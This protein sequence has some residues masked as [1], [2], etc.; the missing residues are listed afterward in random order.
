MVKIRTNIVIMGTIKVNK[1]VSKSGY[2][3]FQ[4]LIAANEDYKT[5]EKLYLSSLINFKDREWREKL[6]D[7]DVIDIIASISLSKSTYADKQLDINLFIERVI[8][9]NGVS[10]NTDNDTSDYDTKDEELAI[11]DITESDLPF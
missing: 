3:Y 6:D 1:K 2:T 4:G 5:K 8:G 7:G 10:D 11:P 9:V